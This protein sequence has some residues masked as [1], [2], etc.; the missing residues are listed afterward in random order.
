MQRDSMTFGHP[1]Q[2]SDLPPLS[3][4]MLETVESLFKPTVYIFSCCTMHSFF[5]FIYSISLHSVYTHMCAS[6]LRI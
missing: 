3:L 5:T 6:H 1:G 2:I 4:D